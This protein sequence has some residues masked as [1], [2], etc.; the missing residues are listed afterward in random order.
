[1]RFE[2]HLA[3]GAIICAILMMAPAAQS[4]LDAGTSNEI[5]LVDQTFNCSNYPQP[6]D[7]DLVKVTIKGGLPTKKDAVH[8]SGLGPECTGRI[9]RLEIDTWAADGV[10]VH[11]EAH[12]L[13]VEGGYIRCHAKEGDVHQDGIQ[14]M[15]G[16]RV[17]FR[18]LEISCATSNNAAMFINAGGGNRSAPEE[19]ICDGCLLRE[20]PGHS[21][22]VLTIGNSIR[23]GAR[24]STVFGEIKVGSSHAGIGPVGHV[25]QNVK[26]LAASSDPYGPPCTNSCRSLADGGVAGPAPTP[27]APTKPKRKQ[28]TVAIEQ[29][30]VTPVRAGRSFSVRFHVAGP[31]PTLRLTCRASARGRLLPSVLRRLAGRKAT[32]T[33]RAPATR[34]VIVAATVT[35]TNGKTSARR[36]VGRRVL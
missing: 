1:M 33:W 7:F 27:Q 20:A 25:L 12:D 10:K 31:A 28:R 2:K 8:L 17:T 13:V 9:G 34:G 3:F 22:Q 29:L 26:K 4:A 36:T 18:K 21:N 23:S 16:H 32:C 15:G 19:I 14:A 11:D 6:V 5:R 35:I 30:S 24:N